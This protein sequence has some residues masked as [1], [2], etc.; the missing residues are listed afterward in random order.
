MLLRSEALPRGYL[1]EGSEQVTIYEALA[2]KL[3]RKPTHAEVKAEVKRIL[4]EG[5]LGE[6]HDIRPDATP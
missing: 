4:E 6:Y 5:K 3:G 2:K 1:D